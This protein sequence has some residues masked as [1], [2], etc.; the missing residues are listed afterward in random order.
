MKWRGRAGS[1]NVSDRRGMGGNLAIGGG[2]GGVIVLI[3]SLLFGG[4]GGGNNPLDNLNPGGGTA[5]QPTAE[6]DENA[7]FVSVVLKDTED[8]WNTLFPNE[9]NAEYQE[10]TLVLFTNSDQ[11]GCGFASAATGP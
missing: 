8:V 6:E 7:Q 5:Y 1:G 4:G 10:P 3:L 9:F 2:L 11:S